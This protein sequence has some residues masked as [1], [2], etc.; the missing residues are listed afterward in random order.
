MENFILKSMVAFVKWLTEND[1]DDLQSGD[2]TNMLSVLFIRRI[3]AYCD[4]LSQKLELWMFVPCKL[5]DGV[6]VVLEEPQKFSD[7]NWNETKLSDWGAHCQEYQESKDRVLF[8]GFEIHAIDYVNVIVRH[9]DGFL[10]NWINNIKCFFGKKNL[11]IE[12][13]VKYNLELT[14]TAQKQIGVCQM[15]T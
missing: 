5:V 1:S 7:E 9:K 8:E 12:D 15:I 13:L 10:M 2:R 3:I 11:T 14:P 6:W 4:F